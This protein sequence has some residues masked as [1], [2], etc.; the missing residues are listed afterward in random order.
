M[1]KEILL[2]DQK[3]TTA[4]NPESRNCDRLGLFVKKIGS[5]VCDLVV[6]L[7]TRSIFE[8]FCNTALFLP[9][10]GPLNFVGRLFKHYFGVSIRGIFVNCLE[11]YCCLFVARSMREVKNGKETLLYFAA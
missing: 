2:G 3:S 1:E 9:H 7:K 4:R 8:I 6:I 5:C 11:S 10:L